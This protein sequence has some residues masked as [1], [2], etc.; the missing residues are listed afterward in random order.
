MGFHLLPVSTPR[1]KTASSQLWSSHAKFKACILTVISDAPFTAFYSWFLFR[2]VNHLW[3]T[4][5]VL[6]PQTISSA[7]G[8]SCK[9]V[10]AVLGSVLNVSALLLTCHG[11][12][13]HHLSIICLFLHILLY[14]SSSPLS[15]EDLVAFFRC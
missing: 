1:N 9:T 8:F 4:S 5:I 11:N 13:I 2:Q 14:N 6:A 10:G 7:L 3:L 12:P 15:D